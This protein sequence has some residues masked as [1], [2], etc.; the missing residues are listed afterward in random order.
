MKGGEWQYGWTHGSKDGLTDYLTS[1][2]TNGQRKR[3]MTDPWTDER[4][5]GRKAARM[6]S[7][8]RLY[9]GRRQQRHLVTRPSIT[10]CS[11]RQADDRRKTNDICCRNLST[12]LQLFWTWIWNDL[13][14]R[15]NVI[16]LSVVVFLLID[17]RIHQTK[18]NKPYLTSLSTC[19][20]NSWV[21]WEHSGS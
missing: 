1:E 18:V 2:R 8:G 7:R 10:L 15:G 5:D 21:F 12:L 16:G 9:P 17:G 4:T 3:R 14:P 11:A 20:H 6:E 13:T 19:S